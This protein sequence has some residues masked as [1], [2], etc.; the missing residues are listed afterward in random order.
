MC[1]S[2]LNLAG[3]NSLPVSSPTTLSKVCIAYFVLQRITR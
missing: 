1:F 3:C 2:L